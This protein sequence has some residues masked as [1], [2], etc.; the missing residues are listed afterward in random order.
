MFNIWSWVGG[1]S[2]AL[3]A[4]AVI[5]AFVAPWL[6]PLVGNTLKGPLEAVGNGA[7][8]L[9]NWLWEGVAQYKNL[10][11]SGILVAVMAV[12]GSYY[13]GTKSVDKV[14]IVEQGIKQ[15]RKDYQFVKRPKKTVTSYFNVF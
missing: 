1:G 8:A 15:L 9:L 14:A 4:L 6:G 13:V 5:A 11:L 3:I 2:I 10:T 12:S 7:G